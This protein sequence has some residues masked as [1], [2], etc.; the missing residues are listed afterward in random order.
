MYENILVPL[1]N[2]FPMILC[3]VILLYQVEKMVLKRDPFLQ[4]SFENWSYYAL[5]TT[6]L[7]FEVMFS[8]YMQYT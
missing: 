8:F 5:T 4:F 6:P 2:E 1:N 3:Y 7:A